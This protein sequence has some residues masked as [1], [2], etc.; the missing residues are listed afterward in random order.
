M[1]FSEIEKLKEHYQAVAD[2]AVREVA[3]LEREIEESR[4]AISAAEK[5]AAE[6]ANVANIKS[7][8]AAN[9][10]VS[11][12]RQRIKMHEKKIVS[13]NNGHLIPDEEFARVI[14]ELE[15]LENNITREA[16]SRFMNGMNELKDITAD[17][18]A[19]MATCASFGRLLQEIVYKKRDRI[20]PERVEVRTSRRL[21]SLETV[22]GYLDKPNY[23]WSSA[24]SDIKRW[25]DSY[26]ND[27]DME[28]SASEDPDKAGHE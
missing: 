20:V 5:E 11:M 28:T 3:R 4:Q 19:Q 2:K 1:K 26:H 10:K 17:Y 21:P 14:G 25:A 18:L 12:H 8:Q 9:N 6:A 13:L 15:Q 27:K 16:A 7:Y 23:E 22:V 24:I